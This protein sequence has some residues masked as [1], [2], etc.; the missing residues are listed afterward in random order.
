MYNNIYSNFLLFED[1]TVEVPHESTL[2]HH[3]QDNGRNRRITAEP[4][5]Q[6]KTKEV[7]LQMPPTLEDKSSTSDQK[8]AVETPKSPGTC[9]ELNAPILF[10]VV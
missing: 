10:L 5:S 3:Q 8:I 1:K 7:Y 6:E 2:H 4:S 9:N